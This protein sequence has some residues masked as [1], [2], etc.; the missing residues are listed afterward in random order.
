MLPRVD[1]IRERP[2]LRD[3]SEAEDAD[4][5]VEDDA[6]V[7]QLELAGDE[8]ELDADDEEDRHAGDQA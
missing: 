4:P 6:D 3:E 7:G 8:E 1:V 5:D 2:E